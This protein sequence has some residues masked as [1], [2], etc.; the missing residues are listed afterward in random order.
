MTPSPP[1]FFT[2]VLD[3][4]EKTLPVY[5]NALDPFCSALLSTDPESCGDAGGLWRLEGVCTRLPDEGQLSSALELAAAA[6]G[7]SPPSFTITPLEDRDWLACSLQS[8]QPVQIG[9]FYISG[10]H[11]SE[12]PPR[13]CLPLK[14]DAATAFGSG[15]H[16]TTR[17]CLQAME[18]LARSRTPSRV[19]DMGCGSGIL[20]LAAAKLWRCPVISVDSDPEAV[21]MTRENARLNRVTLQAFDG[22]GFQGRRVA[23]KGPYDMIFANILARPLVRMA[24]DIRRHL[25]PG[26]YAILSGLLERQKRWVLS[27]FRA[28]GLR[29]TD[30]VVID[31]WAALVVG[32]PA[33]SDSTAAISD[34]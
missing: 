15:E 27:A 28:Q 8:F 4:P 16:Q 18:H 2:I 20:S 1:S 22:C 10:S 6:A 29:R 30:E 32:R 13:T 12:P 34:M 24:P 31:G 9:R 5:E 21:R 17:G 26:G 14:V 11:I 23:E 19:L 33:I 3:V 25:C 7:T